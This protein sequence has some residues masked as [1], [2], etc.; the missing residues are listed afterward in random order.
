MNRLTDSSS[1]PRTHCEAMRWPRASERNGTWWRLDEKYQIHLG[2]VARHG[3]V[4]SPRFC[5]LTDLPKAESPLE[6][7]KKKT[8]LKNNKESQEAGASCVTFGPIG[9]QL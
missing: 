3:S 1:F 4:A 2:S 8:N 7:K 5:C 6:K 9:G